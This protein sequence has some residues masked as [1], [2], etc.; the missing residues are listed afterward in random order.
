[1]VILGTS[2]DELARNDVLVPGHMRV[3]QCAV[4]VVSRA[5]GRMWFVGVG[6]C[7]RNGRDRRAVRT[8]SS[9][10]RLRDEQ[11]RDGEDDSNEK[12]RRSWS[13]HAEQAIN[14]GNGPLEPLRHDGIV[15]SFPIPSSAPSYLPKDVRVLVVVDYGS[16][17][18]R[19]LNAAGTSKLG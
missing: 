5:R 16:D 17:C 13:P 3:H 19:S 12:Q 11:S 7:K 14:L 1:V 18:R 2:R 4:V 8:R 15:W 6:H 10:G 9:R